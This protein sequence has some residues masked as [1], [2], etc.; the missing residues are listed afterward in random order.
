MYINFKI[1]DLK[2]VS[3]DD[4]VLMNIIRQNKFED[5]SE[6][7]KEWG[8]LKEL[9][10]YGLIEYVKGKKDE[11][12]FQRVRLSKLGTKWIE[13][14][15][16]PEINEDDLR[17]YDWLEGIYK[18][19]GREVGNRK[20]TKMHIAQFRV[21]SGISRNA[22]AYLC[23]EFIEDEEEMEYS[24]K[25]EY[26]FFKPSSVYQTKFDIDQSRLYKYYLKH[27]KVFDNAF[28]EIYGN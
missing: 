27:Q 13:D 12:E 18:S 16:T 25:L 26:L 10:K 21:H 2:G 19:L 9:E 22:L 4:Y 11:T 17:I 28:L 24:F 14:I 20:K 23:Q 3:L 1:L 5:V 6:K 8:G 15:Q 7:I